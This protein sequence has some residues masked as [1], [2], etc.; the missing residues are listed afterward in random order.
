MVIH[1]APYISPCWMH[2]SAHQH[3]QGSLLSK[4]S[5]MRWGPAIE[6]PPGTLQSDCAHKDTVIHYLSYSSRMKM[7]SIPWSWLQVHSCCW[8]EGHR[9]NSW[10]SGPLGSLSRTGQKEEEEDA[11]EAGLVTRFPLALQL[12]RTQEQLCAVLLTWSGLVCWESPSGSQFMVW[13]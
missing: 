9:S 4:Q 7:F 6:V 3:P 12:A 10:L 2:L 13:R 1:S 5:W 8:L 11:R